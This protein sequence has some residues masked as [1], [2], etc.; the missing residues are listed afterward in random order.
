MS[1]FRFG[2]LIAGICQKIMPYE[3]RIDQ[4]VGKHVAVFQMEL[5]AAK[6]LQEMSEDEAS[7]LAGQIFSMFLRLHELEPKSPAN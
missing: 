4:M 1:F 2:S 7:K 3:T 6:K 5:F